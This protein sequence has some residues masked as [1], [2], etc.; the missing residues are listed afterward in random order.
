MSRQLIGRSPDLQ[1]LWDEGFDIATTGAWLLVRQVPYVDRRSEIQFAS[2]AVK[3]SLAGDVT[4]SPGDHTAYFSGEEP[5]DGSGNPLTPL[6]IGTAESEEICGE[7]FRIRFS[8]KPVEQG[9]TRS[10][11]DCHEQVSGYVHI[12]SGYAVAIDNSVQLYP[13]VRLPPIESDYPFAYSDTAS[14]RAGINQLSRK[15]AGQIVGII[16]VGGTGSY[17]ADLVAKSHVAELHLWDGDTFLQHNA[18]RAPGAASIGDLRQLQNKSHYIQ[19][20][21]K[22]IHTRV[23]AHPYRMDEGHFTELDQLDFVFLAVDGGHQRGRIIPE[24]LKRNIPFIDVGI[25][26][27]KEC[28]GLS[29]MVRV[30]LVESGIDESALKHIPMTDGS[31]DNEYSEN[32]QIAEINAINA[33]LAVIKW[34]KWAGVYADLG[35]ELDAVYMIDGN[36][37]GNS[38]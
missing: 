3:L 28:A 17:I 20:V 32:I 30:T 26:I 38:R 14:V 9:I 31:G 25:G 18:F 27:S 4:T 5:C 23:I 16:G 29:G 15:V 12:I 6:I 8:H 37:I 36:E 33:V 13:A 24:L 7:S 21:Y 34:K 11:V 22:H 10:Y 1:K 2:L 35:N 19:Q